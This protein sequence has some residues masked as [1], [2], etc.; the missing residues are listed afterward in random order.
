LLLTSMIMPIDL[1]LIVAHLLTELNNKP[2]VFSISPK[3]CHYKNHSFCKL[4]K[5]KQKINNPLFQKPFGLETRPWWL[6]FNS[7]VL[8]PNE[9]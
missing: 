2:S 9:Y 7:L 8:G 4:Y 6:Y 5:Y 3:S 1:Y